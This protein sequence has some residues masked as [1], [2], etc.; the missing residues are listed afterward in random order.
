V[1]LNRLSFFSKPRETKHRFQLE[2]ANFSREASGRWIS[3]T[4][5]TR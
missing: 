1:P 3:L 5:I 2:V 4:Q